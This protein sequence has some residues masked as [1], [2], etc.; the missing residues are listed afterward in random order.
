MSTSPAVTCGRQNHAPKLL[1]ILMRWKTVRHVCHTRRH[2]K[3]ERAG[4]IGC[5]SKSQK[6]SPS[7]SILEKV[8]EE[9]KPTEGGTLKN[10]F[11]GLASVIHRSFVFD[12]LHTKKDSSEGLCPLDEIQHTTRKQLSQKSQVTFLVV[13]EHTV[14]VRFDDPS[15]LQRE[16]SSLPSSFA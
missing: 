3:L 6:S 12:D 14:H 1:G 10:M 8:S 9:H 5:S 15:R 4:G 11:S 13:P 7:I 16:R 2:A